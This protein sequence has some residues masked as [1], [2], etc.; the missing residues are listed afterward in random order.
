MQEFWQK[1][2]KTCAQEASGHGRGPGP[3]RECRLTPHGV[4]RHHPSP[5]HI[6]DPWDLLQKVSQVLIYVGL[7]QGPR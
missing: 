2:Y 4:A 3:T 7:I 1:W 5:C 6:T